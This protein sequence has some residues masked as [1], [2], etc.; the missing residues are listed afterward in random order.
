MGKLLLLFILVPAVELAILIELGRHLGTIP[1]LAII[2]L[3]GTL[4]AILAR[5]EG[6]NVL[7]SAQEKMSRG[8]LPAGSMAD[9]VMI[10]VAAALLVTPGILTD[11]FGFLLL[12]PWFRNVVKGFLLRRF[13]KAVEENRVRV[14]VSGFGFPGE[15]S[16]QGPFYSQN[17][18]LDPETYSIDDET[19]TYK[20]H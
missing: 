16:G 17:D 18:P 19:T 12:V 9:G 8:E 2:V 7:R 10:L 13:R 5:L 15:E 11:A 14:Q 1:T 20:I 4:G 3:T 6:L